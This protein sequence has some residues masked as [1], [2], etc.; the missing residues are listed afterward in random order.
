VR[1]HAIREHPQELIAALAAHTSAI[2][3]AARDSALEDLPAIA[4]LMAGA[5]ARVERDIS[6]RIAVAVRSAPAALLR[7]LLTVPEVARLLRISPGE[8]YRRAKEKEGLKPATVDVG[9]GGL[10][11]DPRELEKLIR[12][13]TG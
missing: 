6:L 10:R 13:R 1:P 11:F 4:A 3:Q 9:P 2:E 7:P 8:V 5:A 12:S